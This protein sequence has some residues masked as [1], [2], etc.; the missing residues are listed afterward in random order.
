MSQANMDTNT[1]TE[2]DTDT[3]TN[4]EEPAATGDFDDLD[5]AQDI[6]TLAYA[7]W[8]R[9]DFD[10]IDACRDLD[11]EFASRIATAASTNS[12]ASFLDRLASKWGVR[13]VHDADGTVRKIVH[14]YDRDGGPRARDF[15]RVARQNNALV[16]LEMNQLQ[17]Q[18]SPT[19]DESNETT[20]TSSQE[21]L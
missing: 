10:R 17:T 20:S 3:D 9:T 2:A 8:R 14:H 15:L 5:I 12:V 6:A 4:T 21:T 13:S 19:T 11:D 18:D 7:V 16:V 1:D